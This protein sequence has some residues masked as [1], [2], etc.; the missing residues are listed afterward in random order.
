MPNTISS[1]PLHSSASLLDELTWR[2]LL[3]QTT[4]PQLAAH[5]NS[6]VRAGYA[7]FDP[8]ADSLTIGNFISIKLLAHLF[9]NA[10]PLAKPFGACGPDPTPDALDCVAY[11]P[12]TP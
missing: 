2:G 5:L 9:A 10:G 12:C 6:G 8:T 4:S 1:T 7:G 3:H 11:N